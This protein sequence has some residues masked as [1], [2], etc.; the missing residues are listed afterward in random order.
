[1]DQAGIG[2]GPI[3]DAALLTG[4]T[5][6]ILI[7]FSRDADVYVLRRPP[8]KPRPRNNE[9]IL[10]EATVLE[11][12]AETKVPHPRLIAACADEKVLGS[13]CFYLMRSVEGFNPAEVAPDETMDA[14]WFSRLAR[15]AT[16]ALADIG[17]LDHV[18]IGL[19]DFG[20]LDQFLE[21]QV[22]RWIKE[23]DRYLTTENYPG[24]PLPGFE[25][26]RDH[27]LANVP[28]SFRPGLMH[29]DYHLGN[30]LIDPDSLAVNAVVDWEMSTLG[31]PLLDL[32]RYLAL[33]PDDHETVIDPGRVWASPLLP[34]PESVVETY[35]RRTGQEIE[36][37]G[38]YR[39]MGCFK[40]GI[41]LE[42]TYARSC[43]G[44]AP[45]DIGLLLHQTAVRLFER[46]SRL[47]DSPDVAP[48]SQRT[49]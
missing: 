8:L 27:L 48:S 29:G 11:A 18:G 15:G 17:Q 7:R 31:D 33:W 20:N 23:R 30:L 35:T 47:V 10:R 46:A 1:M 40:L 12:L 42:G 13:A 32:G 2:S 43:A 38:W 14:E 28:P 6:N 36:H 4:G 41:I 26:V 34:S 45:R 25:R 21:R 16:E 9:L 37:L 24:E 3:S 19:T 39:I 44:Q 22:P 49:S 5:Q